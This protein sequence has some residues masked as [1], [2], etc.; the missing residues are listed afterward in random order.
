VRALLA[1][2]ALTVY[3]ALAA[4]GGD[5]VNEGG[6]TGGATVDAEAAWLDV[7]AGQSL[8]ANQRAVLVEVAGGPPTLTVTITVPSDAGET[9]TLADGLYGATAWTFTGQAWERVDTADIRTEI[10][11]L[12]EPGQ[13]ATVEL[14]VEDADSYRVLVP[15]AAEGAWGDS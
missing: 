6:G 12:L 4:C 1:F 10:A 3:L 7:L 5:E 9:V 11:P 14:P 2:F 15:V 13:S 8:A